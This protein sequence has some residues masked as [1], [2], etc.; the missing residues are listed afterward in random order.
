MQ[1]KLKPLRN[2]DAFDGEKEKA[3][4]PRDIPLQKT[5]NHKDIEVKGNQLRCKCGV[6]Y[7]GA[8]IQQ[9]YLMLKN[10]K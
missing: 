5:C 7:Q 3:D 6:G 2:L 1:Y 8:N 9:L 4:I 10:Q